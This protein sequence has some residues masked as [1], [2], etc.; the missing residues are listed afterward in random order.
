VSFRSMLQSYYPKVCTALDCRSEV[1]VFEKASRVSIETHCKDWHQTS[2]KTESVMC[3]YFEDLT[4]FLTSSWLPILTDSEYAEC[5]TERRVFITD[6][7]LS[8]NLLPPRYFCEKF[9]LVFL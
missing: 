8:G 3:N 2:T 7:F 9:D 4:S 6:S 5:C 1:S